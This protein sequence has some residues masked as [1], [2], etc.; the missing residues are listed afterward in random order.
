MYTS[1]PFPQRVPRCP[2]PGLTC[3]LVTPWAISDSVARSM[4]RD[5]H[6]SLTLAVFAF[7]ELAGVG[8]FFLGYNYVIFTAAN[9]LEHCLIKWQNVQRKAV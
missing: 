5:T 3:G 9:C 1:S 2:A 8:V 4:G 7:L 6:I